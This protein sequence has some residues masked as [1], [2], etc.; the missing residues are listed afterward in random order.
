MD[1]EKLRTFSFV[2]RHGSLLK[3]A[4]YLKITSPAISVQIKK[5][6]GELGITLF[7]RRPNKLTLTE[8]GQLL[9]NEATHVFEAVTRL[10]GAVYNDRS[11]YVGKLKIAVGS[12]L[13][14]FF[15]PRIAAFSQKHPRL[16]IT[17][18]SRPSAEAL[19]LLLEGA[20]DVAIGWFPK[21]PRGIQKARLFSSQMRLV[22][23]SNHPLSRKKRISLSDVARFRIILHT[24][25]AAARRIVDSAFHTNGIE[26]DNSLE[27]G[28]CE[29]IIDFVQ[30][31]LGIGF[32]HEICLPAERTKIR[33][34]DMRREF[35]SIDVSIIYKKATAAQP[36][37][38]MLI[39]ALVVPG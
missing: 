27:V 31:G 11:A 24:S 4:K 14:K 28:T 18:L 3:A 26:M 10:E 7:H 37:Y 16:K 15:V 17:M 23:P 2:A 25:T 12:D 34:I 20:V 33:S 29:S 13:P 36:S 35:G 19:S 32:V 5:L 6:E 30:L 8:R 22:V 9:L 38:R 1:L 39:N 21:V